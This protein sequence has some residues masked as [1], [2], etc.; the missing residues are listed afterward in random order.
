MDTRTEF[1]REA[2]AELRH[3]LRTPL[4][5][6]LGYS[7]M[8]LEDAG[9]LPEAAVEQFRLI[10][11]NG[12]KMLNALQEFLSS[13]RGV[14]AQE[15]DQFRN[16]IIEPLHRVSHAAGAILAKGPREL[17]A[18]VLRIAK[19][20]AELLDFTEEPIVVGRHV[21]L[22]LKS[23]PA[24]VK[25]ARLKASILVVDD[26]EANRDILSRQLQRLGFD[27]VSARS[28]PEALRLLE[29]RRFDIALVDFM[30][31][32]M[33]GL[34]VLE[35]IKEIPDISGIPVIMISALDDLSGVSRCIQHGADDYLFKPFE[36]VLLSARIRAA[37][38]RTRLRQQERERTK[39]LEQMSQELQRS[40]ED[41][42]RFACAASHD[43]QAPL[44]TI[45]THLQLLERRVGKRMEP[46][47]LDLLRFPVQAAIRM[48]QLIK[49]LLVYSQVST[50]DREISPVS[51]NDVLASTLEDLGSAI[52][53]SHATITHDPLP[54]VLADPVQLRQLLLNLIGNAIKYRSERPPHIH[55]GAKREFAC[56]HFTVS[57]NGIGIPPQHL[58]EVFSLFKRLHGHDVPGTG[59]GLSIC[60]RIMERLGGRIWVESREGQGSIFH[61]TIPHEDPH[62]IP[63]EAA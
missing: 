27:V 34:D 53:E 12:Q 4:N 42:K 43:L 31:P 36:P 60:K 17:M 62:Q 35:A 1:S 32:E 52:A 24:P 39:E 7:E 10:Q 47:D 26:D 2:L 20:V 29:R 22:R 61:F 19:G 63:N 9:T 11:S 15:I 21:S 44:R 5:H 59:L 14:S 3:R 30:M 50:E 40:N 54:T 37:L 58:N 8:R 45:T 57:D 55:I 16:Q 25:G 33:D 28:G 51:C 46:A 18:D 41:L 38:E 49:D 13:E 48:S 23:D 6:I 56:W